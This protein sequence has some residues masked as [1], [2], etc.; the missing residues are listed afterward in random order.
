MRVLIVENTSAGQAT[1]ARRLESI[2]RVD[3]DTLDLSIGLADEESALER[4]TT[5]DVLLLGASLGA[6]AVQMARQAKAGN[7]RLNILMFVSDD[8]YIGGA[9]R[10]AISHGTRKVFAESAPLPDIVQE[11]MSIYE[12]FRSHGEIRP[13]RV[14]AVVQAKGGV[15]AT[16]ACAA[17]AEVCGSHRQSSILWDLDIETRDLC[18]S[19]MVEGE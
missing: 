16:S 18:R 2:D 7:A 9:F 3:K 5:C 14:I 12:E 13:S 8:A 15:G 1:T 10:N 6:R 4:L 19:F 11:L 17:L